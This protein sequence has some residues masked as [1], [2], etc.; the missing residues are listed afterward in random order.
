M[1]VRINNSFCE[2]NYVAEKLAKLDA[3]GK[4][5]FM[6]VKVG[7]PT[8]SLELFEWTILDYI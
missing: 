7:F 1:V 8:T 5:A 3:N 4:K 2:T 6:R